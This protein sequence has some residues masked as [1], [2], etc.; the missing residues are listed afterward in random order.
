MPPATFEDFYPLRFLIIAIIIIVAAVVIFSARKSGS[1]YTP[2]I[3]LFI[4][5][6]VMGYFAFM[7]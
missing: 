4:I 2:Y 6:T 3:I 1:G 5:L 7:R